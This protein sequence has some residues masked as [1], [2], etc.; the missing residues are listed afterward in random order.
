MQIKIPVLIS[1]LII[2]IP[3][4]FAEDQGGRFEGVAKRLVEAI[5]C[6]NYPAIQQDFNKIMIK[7][8]PIEKSRPFIKKLIADYGKIER[9]NTPRLTTSGLAVFP[10]QFQKGRLDSQVYISYSP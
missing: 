2:F 3:M 10:A 5:N 9:L 7:A 6:E 1:T 4:V 8:F